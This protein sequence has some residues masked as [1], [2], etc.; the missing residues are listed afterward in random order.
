[1]RLTGINQ[2]KTGEDPHKILNKCSGKVSLRE[3]VQQNLTLSKH[4]NLMNAPLL[5]HN[6]NHE[7]SQC[8]K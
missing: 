1:M 3:S 7:N 2:D 8:C 4:S 5:T 6:R